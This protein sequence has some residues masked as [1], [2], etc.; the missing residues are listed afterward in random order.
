[1]RVEVLIFTAGAKIF[2][3][4][5]FILYPLRSIMPTEANMFFTIRIFFIAGAR[6][7]RADARILRADARIL[8][9]DRK[10]LQADA[11]T[12]NADGKTLRVNA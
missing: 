7:L 5:A 12:L 3:L 11:K 8:N 2:I 9:A 1:M 6:T 10:T 4:T